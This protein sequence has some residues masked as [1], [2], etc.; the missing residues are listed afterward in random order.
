[1]CHSFPQQILVVKDPATGGAC[2]LEALWLAN[3]AAVVLQRNGKQLLDVIGEVSSRTN[4][5][6]QLDQRYQQVSVCMYASSVHVIL[7]AG[8]TC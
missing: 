3:D 1:M 7:L 4:F 6:P 2:K 8:L 5:Q